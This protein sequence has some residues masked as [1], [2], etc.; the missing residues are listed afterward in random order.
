MRRSAEPQRDE[1]LEII[2]G[3]RE[4]CE[5]RGLRDAGLVLERL[6]EAC[7]NPADT[8]TS[9][10]SGTESRHLLYTLD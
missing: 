2:A 5:A 1:L 6:E 4:S 3:L 7:R 8:D 10:T 9:D